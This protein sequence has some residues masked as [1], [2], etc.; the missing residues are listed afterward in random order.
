MDEIS[1][2]GD[3][4]TVNDFFE[5]KLSIKT[6]LIIIFIWGVIC[7]IIVIIAFGGVNNAINYM[8]STLNSVKTTLVEI[9]NKNTGKNSEKN[10]PP[11]EDQSNEKS[12]IE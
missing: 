6:I 5:Y 12:D 4:N 9:K 11:V 8:F 1:K 3:I 2:L 10:N 7:F